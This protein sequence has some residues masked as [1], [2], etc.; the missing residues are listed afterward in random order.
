MPQT[1]QDIKHIDFKLSRE[2][3]SIVRWRAEVELVIADLFTD[4]DEWRD[5]LAG[6][7]EQTAKRAEPVTEVSVIVD[8]RVSVHEEF[9]DR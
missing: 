3:L 7:V 4:L 2:E 9:F 8:A 1:E 5:R 6:I